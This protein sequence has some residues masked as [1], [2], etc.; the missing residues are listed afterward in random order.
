MFKILLPPSIERWGGP[1]PYKSITSH[2]EKEEERILL[3]LQRVQTEREGGKDR[4]CLLTV[5]RSM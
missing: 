1:N 4:C 3:R 5:P 2:S